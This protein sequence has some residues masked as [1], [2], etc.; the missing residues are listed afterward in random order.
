MTAIQ[1]RNDG[2]RMCRP[3]GAGLPAPAVAVVRPRAVS[4]RTAL[5]PIAP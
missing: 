2:T 3:I 5:P 1:N 4:N